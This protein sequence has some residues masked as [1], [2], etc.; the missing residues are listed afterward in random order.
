MS[1]NI[2][3]GLRS[4]IFVPP[5]TDPVFTPVQKSPKDM[6]VALV[7]G[8][9]VHLKSDV[10]FRLSGDSTFRLIPH[11]TPDEQ[12][13]VSHGGYDNRD[14]NRDINAMFPLRALRRLAEEGFVRPSPTHVGF[15]GGGG[16]LDRLT[17]ETGPAIAE[18]L[19]Q[20]GADAA[21]FTAG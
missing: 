12:L 5:L 6:T 4:E 21:V 7:T 1:M 16:D 14:V 9:G 19:R 2:A 15:M 3:Y 18:V 17:H 20:A 13:T 8:A 11:D 10:P